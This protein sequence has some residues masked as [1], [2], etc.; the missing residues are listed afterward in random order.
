MIPLVGYVVFSSSK[1]WKYLGIWLVPIALIPLIWPM[2]ATY[3]GE[4]DQWLKDVGW[5]SQRQ[6]VELDRAVSSILL[7]S[8]KYVFQMDPVFLLLSVAGLVYSQIKRDYFVLLWAI[9]F[10]LFL[11]VINFVSFFHLIPI[12]P[13]FCIAAGRMIV[14]LSNRFNGSTI[15][16]VLPFVIISIIGIFGITSIT[17]IIDTNVTSNYY[18]AY[19]YIVNRASK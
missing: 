12:F 4:F 6:D 2:N 3:I 5:N 17:L 15:R 9:P 18:K 16:K 11:F 14:D 19:A 8:L 10:F 7:N 1:S 13:I